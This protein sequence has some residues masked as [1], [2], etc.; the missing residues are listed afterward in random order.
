MIWIIG[1]NGMLAQDII[2]KFNKNSVEYIATASDID[3]TNIDILNNFSKDKNIKTIINSSAYTKVDL[4]E[5]EKDIYVNERFAT[6]LM[7]NECLLCGEKRFVGSENQS[8]LDEYINLLFYY[9]KYRECNPQVVELA[10]ESFKMGTL[11]S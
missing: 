5:D 6:F 1:K 11:V 9:F 8:R 4:A 10:I 2:D 3:I 7:L